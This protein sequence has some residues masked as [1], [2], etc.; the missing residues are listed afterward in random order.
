MWVEKKY[1][2]YPIGTAVGMPN[3]VLRIMGVDFE[4]Y[5][6]ISKQE[7][8]EIIIDS[9]QKLL[10]MINSKA[11]LQNCLVKR[12]FEKE[13][14]TMRIFIKDINGNNTI[15]DPLTSIIRFDDG[16]LAYLTVNEVDD[17][18][19]IVSCSKESYEEAVEALK[20]QKL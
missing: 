3:G 6:I 15:Y 17:I 16:Y 13:N 19:N 5:R 12:P 11:I 20:N 8:R 9:S 10:F 7:A 4:S 18:P 2:I 14:I 1:K